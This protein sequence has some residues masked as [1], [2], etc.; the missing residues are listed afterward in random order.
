MLTLTVFLPLLGLVLV[1]LAPERLARVINVVTT[2]AVLVLTVLVWASA[3]GGDGGLATYQLRQTVDWIP[4][5]GIHYD[6]G[7]DG[8]GVSLLLLTAFVSLTAAIASWR[9]ENKVRGYHA[10]FL[11]LLTGMLG[12]FVSLDL[13]LF[14]VFWEIMLLPMYFLIGVWGG[15]RRRYAAIKFFLYTLFGSVLLL[16]GILIVV[17]SNEDPATGMPI[18]QIDRLAAIA[19]AQGG[20]VAGKTLALFVFSGMFIGFAVKIPSFPFHTWLPDAHVEAPTPISMILAGVLL[21]MGGY[22]L[23]RIAYPFF[24]EAAATLWWIVATLSVIAI[25]YGALVAMAQTDFKRLI[26]YSSVSHMGFVTLGI[27]SATA[28]GLNGAMYMMLAHGTIS[29]ML[30]FVVGVIYERAHHRDL[31][32]FGGLAWVMPKYGVLASFAF[33]ASLGLPSLSGFIAEVTTFVGAFGSSIDGY[34][35]FAL[36]SLVGMVVTAGYYLITLQKVYLGDTPEVY[37]DGKKFP[38]LS[39]RELAVLVPLALVTLYMGLWP[40]TAMDIYSGVVDKLVP[41]MKAAVEA[42]GVA[43]GAGS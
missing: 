16:A 27:A 1:L 26:A 3:S 17:L 37:R 25:V 12:V 4:G 22:G 31:D 34:R 32:R 36:V 18:W 41:T 28:G 9:I 5:M 7:V 11:L 8:I 10:M 24:P 29:A 39:G 13:F 35:W 33:F 30:F 15:P 2:F 23:I 43:T 14:Y 19:A 6:V 42:V 40:A 20:L 21:K 38:D